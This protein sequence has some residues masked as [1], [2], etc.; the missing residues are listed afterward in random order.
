[1]KFTKKYKII[2]LYL[3]IY[4]THLLKTLNIGIFGPLKRNYKILLVKTTW[5]TTYNI[6][7]TNFI[8]EI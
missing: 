4:L 3:L 7:K 1:M 8:F 5:F 6:D 2:Y